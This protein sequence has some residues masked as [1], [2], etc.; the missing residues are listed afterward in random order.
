MSEE[1]NVNVRVSESALRHKET[2]CSGLI[3]RQIALRKSC[4]GSDKCNL[5]L[6]LIRNGIIF[7]ENALIISFAWRY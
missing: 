4:V 2:I 1:L 5:T 3:C 7:D 6:Y